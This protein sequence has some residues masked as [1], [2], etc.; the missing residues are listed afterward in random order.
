MEEGNLG[1]VEA[2]GSRGHHY[3]TL[4]N[5]TNLGSTLDSI[6]LDDFLEFKGSQIREDQA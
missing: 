4:G 5:H 6:G 1:R 2:S 3:I